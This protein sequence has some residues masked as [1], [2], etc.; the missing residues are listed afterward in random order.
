MRSLFFFLI[1]QLT[2]GCQAAREENYSD[3]RGF[4]GTIKRMWRDLPDL[5]PPNLGR[6]ASRIQ[7]TG[8]RMLT[9]TAPT[10]AVASRESLAAAYLKAVSDVGGVPR[11]QGE[12]VLQQLVAKDST[13]CGGASCF[14][15][16]ELSPETVDTFM[17]AMMVKTGLSTSLLEPARIEI[18][19]TLLTS[20]RPED[21]REFE[22]AFSQTLA[23]LSTG[24]PVK[25]P[26]RVVEPS[27]ILPRYQYHQRG[28]EKFV[29][30]VYAYSGSEYTNIR[31]VE[32]G[33]FDKLRQS[34]LSDARVDQLKNMVHDIN[35]G[36]TK[37]PKVKETIYRGMKDVSREQIQKWRTFWE[38]DEAFGLGV[39]DKP[40]LTSASWDPEVAKKFM[41]TGHVFSLKTTYG[42]VMEITGHQ[43]V[44]IQTIS[45]VLSEKEVLIPSNMRFKIEQMSLLDQS[46]GIIHIKIR[47]VD[48]A[49]RRRL[50][51]TMVSLAA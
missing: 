23:D 3:T 27:T 51:E 15:V 49:T 39:N 26:K 25:L 22:E 6:F 9:A 47:G 38:K 28:G 34:G 21:V 24:V 48:S 31:L 11:H 16:F 44:S 37:C 45:K 7:E 4:G 8:S 5:D 40:G 33:S 29:Q 10:G 30:A 50:S 1:L 41:G 35:E 17:D 43:G 36:L 13:A 20:L 42:V 19:K 2:A 46:H 18:K 12:E 32:S 14:K